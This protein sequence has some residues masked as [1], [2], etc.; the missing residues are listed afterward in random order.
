[1]RRAI[2]QRQTGETKIDLELDLDT[3][4]GGGDGISVPNGFFGHMLRR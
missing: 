3:G 4:A 1:M 2:I